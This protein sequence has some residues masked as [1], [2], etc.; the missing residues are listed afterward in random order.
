MKGLG[1]GA[2]PHTFGCIDPRRWIVRDGQ[3]LNKVN[4]VAL[5]GYRIQ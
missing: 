3:D 1:G 5:G 4:K 2:V